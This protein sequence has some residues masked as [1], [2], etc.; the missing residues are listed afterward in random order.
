[1]GSKDVP[2]NTQL[3]INTFDFQYE[4]NTLN[5]IQYPNRGLRWN[6]RATYSLGDE[7]SRPGTTSPAGP[8]LGNSHYWWNL[9]A[10]FDWY[11]LHTKP[12]KLGVYLEGNMSTQSLFSNYTAS[13]LKTPAFKPTPES[14]TLFLESF[15][16]YDFAGVGHK[17]IFTFLRD[18]DLRFEAY[19]MQSYKEVIKLADG[20]QKMEYNS[21]IIYGILM[22]AFV[23]NSPVGPVSF[24]TNYY[25]NVPEV[26]PEDKAPITFL[27]HFGYILFNRSSIDAYRF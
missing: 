25:S 2:D 23:Y 26:I 19:A 13:I 11:Y 17:L 14:R 16:K 22:A 24:S 27:F 10:S 18:F 4:Y 21:D 15:H 9:N 6:T 20:S 5:R 12:F 3:S 1:F 8:A 7:I